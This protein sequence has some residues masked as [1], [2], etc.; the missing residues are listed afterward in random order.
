MQGYRGRGNVQT[1][2]ETRQSIARLMTT[3]P[4]WRVKTA[5]AGAIAAPGELFLADVTAGD[6]TIYLPA[7]AEYNRGQAIAVKKIDAS[8]NQVN[9]DRIGTAYTVDGQA[10]YSLIGINLP[11]V[12]FVSDGESGWW[13]VQ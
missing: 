5:V 2:E 13:S 12:T 8:V 3:N 6:L 10:G 7:P 9:I 1:P 4:R 11:S